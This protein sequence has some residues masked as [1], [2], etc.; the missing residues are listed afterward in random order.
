MNKK[1][2]S[3]INLLLIS[4]LVFFTITCGSTT[5]AD[6]L[7]RYSLNSVPLVITGSSDGQ[8]IVAGSSNNYVYYFTSN[9]EMK[10]RSKIGDGI[11]DLAISSDG[12]IVVV[13]SENSNVYCFD[14]NGGLLWK[15][16]TGNSVYSVAI[17][18]KIGRAH[19]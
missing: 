2:I 8:N 14:N 15:Y 7:W 13:G 19:V 17:S 6:Y 11:N 10:W 9:G 4:L 1:C 16:P 18:P 3:K 12:R 5:Q